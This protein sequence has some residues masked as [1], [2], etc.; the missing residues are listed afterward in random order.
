MREYCHNGVL[1]MEKQLCVVSLLNAV[2]GVNKSKEEHVFCG[3]FWGYFQVENGIW[4]EKEKG[5][6]REKVMV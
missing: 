2:L 1:P 6:E 5:M 4:E 3:I